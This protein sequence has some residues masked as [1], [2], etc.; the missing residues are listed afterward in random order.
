MLDRREDGK[1]VF[2]ELDFKILAGDMFEKC[3]TMREK[4]W[5][6]EQLTGCIEVCAEE[7]EDELE[8]QE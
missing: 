2:R 4:E 1:L 3:K 5:L 7:R 8:C 6:E